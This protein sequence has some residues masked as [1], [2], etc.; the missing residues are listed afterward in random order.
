LLY[1]SII[2]FGKQEERRGLGM[3]GPDEAKVS[4]AQAMTTVDAKWRNLGAAPKKTD[5][6]G[7]E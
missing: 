6:D 4:L 1:K 7:S 5:R 3:R 2:S